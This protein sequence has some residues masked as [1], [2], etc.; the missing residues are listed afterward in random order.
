MATTAQVSLELYLHTAYEP[1]AEYVDGEIE[2]RPMG[3]RDHA[4]WQSGI[5]KWFWKHEDAWNVVVL[6]ELRVQTSATRFRVPDVSILDA[7]APSEQIPTHPPLA[8]FEVLSPEDRIQRMTR[9][10]GDYERM[11]IPAIWVIDPKTG[12][13]SC[14]EDGQLV[15]RSEFRLA[16]RRIAFPLTEIAKLVR[17]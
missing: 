7:G 4:S 8:V 3:E 2:E 5:Q 16:E 11:G 12:I 17:L 14:V 1:D 9:K 15:R 6:A 10:L 13:F